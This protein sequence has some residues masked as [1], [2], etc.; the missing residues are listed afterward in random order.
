MASSPSSE[1]G[2]GHAHLPPRGKAFLPK[3][4]HHPYKTVTARTPCTYCGHTA[5]AGGFCMLE[6]LSLF[7][8]GGGAYAA[9][10]LAW[11]GTT[12]W[13]MFAAGGA[14][15]C[16][17]KAGCC[18]AAA[19]RGRRPGR[20]RRQRAGAGGGGSLPQ[21]AA[22]RGV[23]LYRRVGECGR[24]YLPAVLL[25]LVFALRVGH[26]CAAGR[27]KYRL[28]PSKFPV[29]QLKSKLSYRLS[30]ILRSYQIRKAVHTMTQQF[31]YVGGH[32]EVFSESGEFLFSADTMQEAWEE[33]SA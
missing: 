15:H 3:N 27:R 20:S 7:F 4:S 29:R 18:T 23:G 17:L 25:L 9:L 19:G 5:C 13:T 10:E 11:R 6:Q 24:A 8:L 22:H 16:L 12:H 26:L 32:I 14:C 33:L 30:G 2:R 31:R 28:S 21:P 1:R